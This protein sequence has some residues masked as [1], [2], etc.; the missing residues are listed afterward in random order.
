MSYIALYSYTYKK[1]VLNS[2]A[3]KVEDPKMGGKGRV[4]SW[5]NWREKV[6]SGSWI[7]YQL[8][9]GEIGG[10]RGGKGRNSDTILLQLKI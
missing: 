4:W 7:N 5:R 8:E 3:W 1:H 10:A 9:K 6:E 2:V